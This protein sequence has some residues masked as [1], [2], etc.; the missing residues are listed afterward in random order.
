MQI[1]K[2]L[3]FFLNHLFISALIVSPVIGVVYF[4]WY[5]YPLNQI[6]EVT[7]IFLMMSIINIIVGP[8]LSLLIYKTNKKKLFFDLVIIIII[9]LTALSYGVYSISQARPAWIVFSVDRFELVRANE[10]SILPNTKVKPIYQYPSWFGP[11]YV[12]VQL[13]NNKEQKEVDMF[14]AV[15]GLTL[16]KQPNRYLDISNVKLDIKNKALSLDLLR[17]FNS[18]SS[19]DITLNSYPEANSW[20]PLH[21]STKDCVVLIN[22]NSSK[23]ISIVNLKPWK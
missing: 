3:K 17:E 4:V 18:M 12:A 1:S 14:N 16:A 9:Q 21:S 5:P 15:F 7:H 2:R 19:I 22:R 20:I 11:T 10:I 23:I 8:I 6:L 13:S